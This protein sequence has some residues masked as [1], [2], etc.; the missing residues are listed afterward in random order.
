MTGKS[1]YSDEQ[2]K[3][4]VKHIL[5]GHTTL[6]AIFCLKEPPFTEIPSPYTIKR[7]RDKWTPVI[8]EE[9]RQS[10][11]KQDKARKEHNKSKQKKVVQNEFIPIPMRFLSVIEDIAYNYLSSYKNKVNPASLRKREDINTL[12]K[13]LEKEKEVDKK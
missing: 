6:S 3:T 9:E 4:V 2:Q 10:R 8:V 7:W 12:I 5:E 13:I 1:K 11:I